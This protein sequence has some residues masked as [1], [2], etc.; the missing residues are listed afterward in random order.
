M[1]LIVDREKVKCKILDAFEECVRDKPLSNV[2]L[3]DIAKK[4]GMSHPK[5]LNYFSSKEDIILTYCSCTQ[6]NMIQLFEAWFDTHDP[7]NYSSPQAYLDAF[8]CYVAGGNKDDHRPR[9]RIQTMIL[10]Q[11]NQEIRDNLIEEFQILRTML[12]QRLRRVYGN[13]IGPDQAEVLMILVTGVIASCY[14]GTLTGNINKSL[15]S[16][17]LNFP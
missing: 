4:A 17:F 10:A 13:Q 6:K 12:E 11:Y 1:P 16:Q 3:R 8:L 2:S 14:N 7:D 15:F 9:A 5:L